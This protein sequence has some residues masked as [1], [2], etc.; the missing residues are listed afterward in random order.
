MLSKFS[1]K[2]KGK[3]YKVFERSI[4]SKVTLSNYDNWLYTFFKHIGYSDLDKIV[5][6]PTKKLQDLLKSWVMDIGEKLK[7]NTVRAYLAAV[8]HFLEMNEVV[9]HKKIIRKLIANDDSILGGDVPF[10]TDE[11]KEWPT[12]MHLVGEE[13]LSIIITVIITLYVPTHV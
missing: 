13:V 5:K 8:E 6:L 9:F 12:T 1:E 11:I 3:S 2:Q 7:P 4:K 10:T